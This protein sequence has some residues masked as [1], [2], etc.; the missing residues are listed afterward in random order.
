MKRIYVIRVAYNTFGIYTRIRMVHPRKAEEGARQGSEIYQSDCKD[1]K[2]SKGRGEDNNQFSN[3]NF[4]QC[5]WLVLVLTQYKKEEGD[6]GMSPK[7]D[8]RR[9]RSVAI[10]GRTSPTVLFDEDDTNN[11]ETIDFKNCE[12]I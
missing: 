3:W 8:G 7:V 12:M 11:C 9:E 10:M 1:T 4:A 2:N 5:D 6:P